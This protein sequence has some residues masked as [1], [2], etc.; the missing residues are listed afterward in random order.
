VLSYYSLSVGRG[1]GDKKTEELLY[2]GLTPEEVVSFVRENFDLGYHKAYAIARIAT[3]SNILIVSKNIR[4]SKLYKRFN[5][6]EEALKYAYELVG[7][8]D[9]LI[10]PYASSMIPKDLI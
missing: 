7:S 2:S 10:L 4:D 6:F 1:V 5:N 9:S 3:K 8:G